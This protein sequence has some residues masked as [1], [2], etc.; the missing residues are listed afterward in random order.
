[1]KLSTEGLRDLMLSEGTVLWP[2]ADSAGHAT[3]GVGHLLHRGGVTAVDRRRWEG[4]TRADAM[5]LLRKD[6]AKFEAAVNRAVGEAALEK[7]GQRA[8]D[9]M[10]S[11]AFNIGTVGFA[12]STVARRARAGDR[13]GAADAFLMWR[14]PPELLPRRQRERAVFL[15]SRPVREPEPSPADWL[16]ATELRRVRELDAIRAG[17]KP[18]HP[19]REVVL[20]RVLVEQRKRIWRAAQDTGWGRAHRHRRYQSLL[21]RTR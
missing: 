7:L 10:L 3:I 12:G 14:R 2:Y 17:A 19:R 13:T 16:T 18:A 11:L 4:F 21:G 1:V 9:A 15:S 5:A 20:V 6:V 8:F